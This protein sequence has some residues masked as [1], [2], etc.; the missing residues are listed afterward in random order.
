MDAN[1]LQK[2]KDISYSILPVCTLCKFSFFENDD[3]GLCRKHSY[4]HLKHNEIKRQLSIV[5]FGTCPDFEGDVRRI[6]ELGRFTELFKDC[7]NITSICKES[8][9]GL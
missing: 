8:R 5:K 7:E 3:W 2:L 4:N 1:K 6:L 9:M